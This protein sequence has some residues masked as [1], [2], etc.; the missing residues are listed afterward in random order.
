MME[1]GRLFSQHQR[2]RHAC[3]LGDDELHLFGE[4][5]ERSGDRPSVVHPRRRSQ[6]GAVETAVINR[7]GELPHEVRIITPAH[8]VISERLPGITPL[9]AHQV[10]MDIHYWL[11][12]SG[13]SERAG[14]STPSTRRPVI[15]RRRHHWISP[16]LSNGRT[17]NATSGARWI[18]RSILPTSLWADFSL[19]HLILRL[20]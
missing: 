9:L 6:Q 19:S 5:R 10:P 13:Y 12:C 3:M 11:L 2:R 20:S 18:T 4:R 15:R 8:G 16:M 17:V 1:G 7:L 14:S